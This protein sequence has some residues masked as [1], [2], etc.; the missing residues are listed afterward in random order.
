MSKTKLSYHDQSYPVQ[1]VMKNR[2]E[3]DMTYCIGLVYAK[4]ETKLSGP[5]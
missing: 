1:F 4:T 3:N 5:S 2:H